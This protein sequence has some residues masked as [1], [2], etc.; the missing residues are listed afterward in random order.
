MAYVKTAKLLQKITDGGLNGS[1]FALWVYPSDDDISGNYF[2]DGVQQGLHV[3]DLVIA[4]AQSGGATKCYRVSAL[5]AFSS[6][7]TVNADR[8]ATLTAGT[9]ITS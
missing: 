7:A 9:T 4:I 2:S 8:Y 5:Q 1:G 6:T 3:G